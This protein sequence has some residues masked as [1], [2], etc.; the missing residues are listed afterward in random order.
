MRAIARRV[1]LACFLTYCAVFPGSVSTVALDAVPAWGEWMG[2]ALLVVQGVAVICW[3]LG[4]YSARGGLAVAGALL[5]AWTVEHVGETTGFPFGRYQYTEMLQPQL[6][7]VVPV[8]ITLAW[9]MAAF[10]SWQLSLAVLARTTHPSPARLPLLMVLTGALVVVLDLQI[11]TVATFINPYWRWI[12][13]G[14]YYGVPTVNFVAWWGVGALMALVVT[15]ALGRQGPM[16]ED[17]GPWT[18]DRGR[19]A[20]GRG[21]LAEGEPSDSLVFG[22]SSLVSLLTFVSARIP[23]LLYI[24]SSVMFTA[25]NLARGYPLAGMVGV[26][27]LAVL[28]TFV[29]RGATAE[30]RGALTAR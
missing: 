15:V 2:T 9:L 3:M 12:D 30:G 8:P 20:S 19:A 5:L 23:A 6:F 13:S 14:P 27:F 18:V 25:V 21:V 16:I 7:G 1:A 24:L 29:L 11:E 22:R 28:A 10:G 4:A 17:R 26:V